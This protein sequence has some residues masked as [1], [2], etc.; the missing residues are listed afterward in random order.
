MELRVLHQRIDSLEN[1]AAVDNM[2]KLLHRAETEQV[3]ART[4]TGSLLLIQVSGI[5]RASANF[6]SAVVDELTAAF[7]RRLRNTLPPKSAVGR[8]SQEEFVAILP[9]AKAEAV[10]LAKWLAE[11][12]SGAY[13]CL[14]GGKCVRPA[15]QLSVGVVE[16]CGEHPHRVLVK[17][18]E[19]LRG[20]E[21]ATSTKADPHL[22]P[23]R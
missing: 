13:S 7:T 12:L 21:A 14:Q 9:T 1:A 10:T 11:H 2:S 3:I 19:F 6:E 20:E 17:V 15:L 4:E 22:S 5:R 18:S 16:L 23:V 8:W